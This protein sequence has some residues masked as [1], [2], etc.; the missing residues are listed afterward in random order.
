[1][2]SRKQV[3]SSV[4]LPQQKECIV[5][6]L[7]AT[8]IGIFLGATQ[9]HNM[10]LFYSLYAFVDHTMPSVGFVQRFVDSLIVYGV[11]LGVVLLSLHFNKGVYV[12]KGFLVCVASAYAFT[13]TVMLML[14]GGRGLVIIALSYMVQMVCFVV[15]MIHLAYHKAPFKVK[16]SPAYFFVYV[17]SGAIIFMLA[18]YNSYIQPLFDTM[19]LGI[20][21]R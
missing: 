21:E 12:A 4:C 20:L 15:Y 6:L 5:L 3:G 1:M 9:K 14:Y 11:Q 2:R 17:E 10:A 8:G 16:A 7:V 19:I 13:S 18:L